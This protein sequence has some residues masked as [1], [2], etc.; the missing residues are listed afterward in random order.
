MKAD[1]KERAAAQ[2][3]AVISR[4]AYNGGWNIFLDEEDQRSD[5]ILAFVKMYK[6]RPDR[7][8]WMHVLVTTDP[9]PAVCKT[10]YCDYRGV[11]VRYALVL[12]IPR[13]WPLG[14]LDRRRARR[15]TDRGLQAAAALERL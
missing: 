10:I 2:M 9:A 5:V 15:V 14:L 3:R 6:L 1:L 12:P 8:I 11:P 13:P 4:G 7:E